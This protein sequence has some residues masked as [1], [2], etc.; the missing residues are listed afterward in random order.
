MSMQL[1]DF[2]PIRKLASAGRWREA[3]ERYARI[4]RKAGSDWRPYYMA[5]MIEASGGDF[6]R[7][8]KAL[9]KA[10]AQAPSEPQIIINLAQVQLHRGLPTEA[11]EL[12]GPFAGRFADNPAVQKLYGTALLEMGRH[13]EAAP[14]LEIALRQ[15]DDPAVLNNLALIYRGQGDLHRA[16][17][18]L[19]RAMLGDDSIEIQGNLAGIYVATG[20]FDEARALFDRLAESGASDP[21]A[22][23]ALA[24]YSRD[25]GH[26]DRGVRLA[27]RALIFDPSQVASYTMLAELLD[28]TSAMEAALSVARRGLWLEPGKQYLVALE[29]RALRRLKRFDEATS[30][31]REAL[32]GAVPGP[33]MHRLGFELAQSLDSQGHYADAF[34]WFESA[35]RTQMKEFR[36]GLVD[37][38]RAFAEV[39]TL[40]SAFKNAPSWADNGPQGKVGETDPVFL[41]GF[42]R[43]GTT[44]LDQVLDAH[45]GV[46]VLEERPLISGL[47]AR[48]AVTAGYPSALESLPEDVRA[49]MRA[50]YF[51]ERDRFLVPSEGAVYIDK[52]PLNIVHAGLIMRIFPKARFILALRHPCDVC[53]SCLMQ[54][55]NLNH[56]MAVFCSL[57]DTARF[58]R[59]VFGLWRLYVE[60]LKPG[61][62]TVKYEDMT[63]DLQAA[64]EPVLRFLGLDWDDRMMGFHEHARR[65]GHIATPS[66]AQVTQPLYGHA[67]ARWKRYGPAMEVVAEEL[68]PE[69]KAFG[70]GDESN[71]TADG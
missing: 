42:P 62:V 16:A 12:L 48:L 59:E 65:R 36:G 60:H 55:F 29:G 66:Y 26:A 58:Y 25:T 15:G 70:Y 5:G 18:A 27:T 53:L 41:V 71:G 52:M 14:A 23:R 1:S 45:P 31:L 7:A 32:E 11:L 40:T 17:V 35:N 10:R 21:R 69:I 39:E 33:D 13:D 6:D 2:D 43:S 47:S 46:Q 51:A 57:P 28:R 56:S 68:R 63:R 30:C 64:A 22:L 9:E 50:A 20:R 24:V 38:E 8:A 4:L 67:V 54:N 61:I 44:L 34:T 49:E 3:R 19:E 37:P